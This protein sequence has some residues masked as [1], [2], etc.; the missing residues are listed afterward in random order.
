MNVVFILSD[1]HHADYLGCYGNKITRTPNLDRLAEEGTRFGYTFC[2]SPL[3]VPARAALM[4]GRYIHE[5]GVWCNATPWDAESGGWSF[6]FRENGVQLSSIGKL[7]FK[8]D[9]DHGFSEE[10]NVSHR[11]SLDIHSLFREQESIPRFEELINIRAPRPR[12][13]YP[14]GGKDDI[15][16]AESI[17]WIKE[18]RPKDKPWLLN[19]N[20][21]KPHPVWAPP[22]DIWDYYD[23]LVKQE[24]LSEKYFEPVENLHPH[25]QSFTRY[26]NR[27][28]CTPEMIRK[29]QVGFHGLVDMLD[30]Q[31]GQ[32][33]D[34]LEEEGL[35]EDTL[36]IYSSDHGANVHAHQCWSLMNV[37]DDS[38]R[39]PL[40]MKLPKGIKGK[41]DTQATHHHDVYQTICEALGLPLPTEFR[42]VSL[43]GSLT[44]EVSEPR[45]KYVM[46]EVHANG[47]PAAAFAVSD[48]TWKLIECVGE[49]PILFNLENDPDEMKD[50]MRIDPNNESYQA[51]VKKMQVWL[52]A[53]CSPDEM[54]KLAKRDQAR[55]KL[56][57]ENT[58]QLFSE[59][60]KRGYEP[61]ANRLIPK[62]E[63]LDK[64]EID[65][66]RP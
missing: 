58:G 38:A 24:D 39:V 9:C 30:R 6:Y 33:I 37:Y 42:G 17:R 57:L 36:I 54:D 28:Y 60:E 49:R 4:S 20:F 15:T 55:L 23:P 50:L 32:V 45:H 40:I 35:L 44:E 27:E 1:H 14:K 66:K 31:I 19:I 41:L 21:I 46:S 34:T 7:D 25:F 5:V 22:R 64:L 62:Q 8:P 65:W 61:E 13:D 26:Q 29:S 43:L 59:M 63:L 11:S 48:G 56:E 2:G 12:D 51:Q 16:T 18:K 10:I 52:Y 53:I 47:W 3:C